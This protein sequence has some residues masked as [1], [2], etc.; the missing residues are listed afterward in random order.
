VLAVGGEG[1]PC[2]RCLFEDL[3][4]GDSPS[5]AEVGVVGPMVGVVASIQADLAL[6]TIDGVDV[7][8][9]VVAYDGKTDAHRRRVLRPRPGCALCDARRISNI[10]GSRYG[11]A[12]F[13]NS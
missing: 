8:G 13:C 9:T 10:E 6:A 2:Y 1:R 7:A 5:C 4:E 11:A 12:P 3:P